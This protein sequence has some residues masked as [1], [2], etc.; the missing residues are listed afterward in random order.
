[1]KA[2]DRYDFLIFSQFL[3][4]LVKTT[5]TKNKSFILI[6]HQGKATLLKHLLDQRLRLFKSS[7]T[8]K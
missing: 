8:L 1:M 2:W 3:Y 7:K 5:S 6:F 4:M